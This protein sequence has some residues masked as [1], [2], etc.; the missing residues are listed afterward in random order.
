MN[1]RIYSPGWRITKALFVNFSLGNIFNMKNC[2]LNRANHVHIW[3]VS[4][5]HSCGHTCHIQ[6]WYWTGNPD[7]DESGNVE[8]NGAEEIGLV[9]PITVLAT[10]EQSKWK[11]WLRIVKFRPAIILSVTS[12]CDSRFFICHTQCLEIPQLNRGFLSLDATIY[13]SMVFFSIKILRFFKVL[14]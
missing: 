3:Q 8:G 7:F 11:G 14:Y 9:T 10:Y 6:K 13:W 2:L 5:Q 4:P 1:F 12:K